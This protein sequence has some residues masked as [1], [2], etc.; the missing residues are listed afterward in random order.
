MKE[1]VIETSGKVWHELGFRGELSSYNLS[2]VLREEE[3]VVNLALGWLAREDKV[4]Y[5]KKRN[6][7]VFSLVDSEIKIFQSFYKD[8]GQRK[9][10]FW[11]KLFR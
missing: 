9:E 8:A 11:Q 5:S 1:K 3:D 10:S 2:R 7:M 4:N 6:E